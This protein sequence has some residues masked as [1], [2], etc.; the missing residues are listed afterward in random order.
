M[1]GTVRISICPSTRSLPTRFVLGLL[2]ASKRNISNKFEK[3]IHKKRNKKFRG[4]VCG[5]IVRLSAY[6]PEC[7]R[8]TTHHRTTVI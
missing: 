6:D 5:K 3:Y 7:V 4:D 8:P 2:V 1:C